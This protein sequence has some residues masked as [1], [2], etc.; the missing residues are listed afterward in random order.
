LTECIF[1]TYVKRLRAGHGELRFWV[2]LV[3]RL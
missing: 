3:D 1:K 2:G